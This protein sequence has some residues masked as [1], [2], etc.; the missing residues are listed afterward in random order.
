MEKDKVFFAHSS[1][2]GE[3]A[4]TYLTLIGLLIC[5]KIHTIAAT[6]TN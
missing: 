2:A 4:T 6:R 1:K 5:K 3:A